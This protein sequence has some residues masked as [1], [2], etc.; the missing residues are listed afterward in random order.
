MAGKNSDDRIKCS[1]CG[2]PQGMVRKLISGPNGVFICD[3]CI[4]I[5]SDIIMEEFDDVSSA[6]E[7]AKG[8]LMIFAK[9]WARYV[10]P[11]PVGP[12]IIILLFCNST[13]S[14]SF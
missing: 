13:S 9:V 1:F 2:K 12:I 6:D 8:T 7:M 11:D 4:E 14:S 3:E 5:C 10:L